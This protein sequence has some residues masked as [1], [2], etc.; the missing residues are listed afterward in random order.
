M[1]SEDRNL[2]ALC[3]SQSASTYLL[4]RTQVPSRSDTLDTLFAIGGCF[5]RPLD[6]AAVLVILGSMSMTVV[7]LDRL[8]NSDG[9]TQ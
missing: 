2:K 7:D 3:R 6:C 5:M 8:V 4:S 1:A 9:R